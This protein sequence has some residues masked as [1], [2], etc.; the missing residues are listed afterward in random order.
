MELWQIIAALLQGLVEWLPISSEGQV[1]LFLYNF[2]SVPVSELL[3]VVVWL[4][5]GTAMAVIVRYPRV[6]LD[7]L[8]LRDRVLFRNI[9]IATVFTTITAIP[10]YLLLKTTLAGFN[11]EAINVLVGILLLVTA[12]ML[13]IPTRHEGEIDEKEVDDK[14]AAATGLV[15]GF[16]VMPGLSRSG[17]TVSAL[18]MQRVNKE[19][20]LKFSFLI[21][22]PAVF[23]ILFIEVLT[24]GAV[25]PSIPISD[26]IVMEIIVFVTAL[27]SMEFL[28]QIAKRVAFWKL[29]LFLAIVAIVF[30]LP[31][32]F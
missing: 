22:V 32:L 31:A 9:L 12:L 17:V 13:Y 24:G 30:G 28:L 11:G 29:C 10:L 4:H 5:L 8:S 6:I 25:M 23:G 3:T 18:L 2:S 15:Q 21:S 14:V 19:T 26:V 27:V 7:V 1:I 16:S 20:A